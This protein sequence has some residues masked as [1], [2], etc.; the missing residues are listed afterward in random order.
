MGK[1]QVLHKEISG[2]F[3]HYE[4][5][6]DEIRDI[7]DELCH[8]TSMAGWDLMV[9]PLQVIMPLLICIINWYTAV[10]VTRVIH[11]DLGFTVF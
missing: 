1:A 6:K 10:Q 11:R 8:H 3:D 9:W 2:H 4:K 7:E 5:K